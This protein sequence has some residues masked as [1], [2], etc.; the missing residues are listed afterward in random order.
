MELFLIGKFFIYRGALGLSLSCLG[1]EPALYIYIYIYIYMGKFSN[2]YSTPY[3]HHQS[4]ITP[5]PIFQPKLGSYDHNLI[6]KPST[7][8]HRR[9]QFSQKKKK[10]IV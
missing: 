6:R 4:S 9:N 1:L 5:A 7:I 8:L 3:N 2:D 10:K